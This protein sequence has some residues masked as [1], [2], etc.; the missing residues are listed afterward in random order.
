MRREIS[1]NEVFDA[2]KYYRLLMDSMAHPGKINTLYEMDVQPPAGLNKGAALVAFSLL[3]ADVSFHCIDP[4]HQEITR[5]I[6]LNTS[7]SP[8]ETDTADFIFIDGSDAGEEILSAKTGTLPYPEEGASLIVNVESISAA[9]REESI[10]ISVSGPG[11][12]TEESFFITGLNE[13][14]LR[15]FSVMNREFPLGIDVIFTDAKN[16]IVCIPRS[17]KILW[18]NNSSRY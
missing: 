9:A 16:N 15:N 12:L 6:V 5:Y 7:A 14:I 3:N 4:N 18:K 11:V 8:A 10:K 17:N 13:N 2:Q 1:Y